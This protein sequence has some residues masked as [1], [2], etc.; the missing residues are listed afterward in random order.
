MQRTIFRLLQFITLVGLLFGVWLGSQRVARSLAAPGGHA[1]VGTTTLTINPATNNAGAV[2]ELIGAIS[3]ANADSAA[4]T[5]NLFPNGVYTFSAAQN[6][7]FGP[8]ALPQISSDITI[9]GNG[10]TLL[11]A[12]N[13]PKFRFF[14]VSGG[15]SF[16]AATG[17][18]LR[19]GSLTLKDLTMQDGLARGGTSGQGGG[20]AGLGGAIFNQ[21]TLALERV[22]MT[23]NT[24]QGGATNNTVFNAGGGIGTD[25]SE[26]IG[27]GPVGGGFGTP[28]AG[29][30]GAGGTAQNDASGAGGGGFRP[31][32]N[33]ASVVANS[34]IGGAG[35]GQGKLGGRGENASNGAGGNNGDGG[36]GGGGNAFFPSSGGSYGNAGTFGGGGGV[37]GGGG[38]GFIGRAA[39]G[40][41]FGGGGGQSDGAGGQGGFGGG[42]G[43][44]SVGG[45]GGFGGGAG[46]LNTA[47]FGG[48]GGAGGGM[49]GALFNLAGTVTLTNCTLSGNTAQGGDS[50]TVTVLQNSSSGNGGSGFGGALFNLNGALTLNNCTVASNN[51]IAGLGGASGSNGQAQGGA[52]YNL[53]FGNRITDG[54][55]TTASAIARNSIFALSNVSSDVVCERRNGSQTNMATVNLSDRNLVMSLPP[56]IGGG[57]ITGTPVSSNNPG[58][59][60]LALNRPGLT[61]TQMIGN[62]SPAFNQGNAATCAAT[63][64]RG[65][66]R[67]REG[68]C[69]LGAVE[70]V[71]CQTLTITPA[72]LPDAVLQTPYT[73][74]LSSTPG[75]GQP[76]FGLTSGSLPPGLSL[77]SNGAFSGV[78]T[79]PGQFSF[80]VTVSDIFNCVSSRQY[81]LNVTANCA[82]SLTVNDLGDTSDALAGDGVCADAAGHCTL[83]AAIEEAGALAPC[84]EIAINLNVAGVINLGTALPPL[85][86]DLRLVGP[87]A[88]LLTIQRQAAALFRILEIA[89]GRTLNLSGV[90]VRNGSVSGLLVEGGGILTNGYSTLTDCVIAD[91]T[92]NGGDGGGLAVS[93][94]GSASLVRTIV[95]NNQAQGGQGFGGGI[96]GIGALSLTNCTVTGN[97]A[98]AGGGGIYAGGIFLLEN[99]SVSGNVAPAGGG[100]EVAS[101]S[102]KI[103]NSTI[104]GNTVT[105]PTNGGGLVLVSF[106]GFGP[107]AWELTL[108][109]TTLA[110]NGDNIALLNFNCNGSMM[111][112]MANTLVVG[113]LTPNFRK[114]G[115]T[116]QSLGHNLD[117]DG[118][119]GLVNGTLNDL[120]G[121]QAMPLDARLA[122][123]S[124]YG[125]LTQTHALLC[126]S[127]A[128][129]AGDNTAATNQG[130]TTDQ[131]GVSR[132]INGAVDIGAFE[133][134]L[135]INGALPN[136][137]AN[138]PYNQT[139]TATGGTGNKTFALIGGALPNG[140]ALNANGVLTGIPTQIGTFN[141]TMLATDAAGMAGVCQITL[142]ITCPVITVRVR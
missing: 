12:A 89:G 5:I 130:L 65:V 44:G 23:G 25:A 139:L 35:G 107:G 96:S 47:I 48:V 115:A 85:T 82:A 122:P 74:T 111:L 140:L 134:H 97:Q 2:A 98:E 92:S 3:A 108:V 81:T 142:T 94:A 41:G 52:L 73:Q 72:T 58:L 104:S 53:A 42:G 117:S 133:N 14:Y 129:D 63:D 26:V 114:F 9:L 70:F 71:S 13:A 62:T 33:G 32:D 66:T 4:D 20:G 10:A 83:R 51:V 109:N 57:T 24:A 1:V 121:T 91:S 124:N 54:G 45:S 36:G 112:K 22:T 15:L 103:V 90:T 105:T 28:F 118:S 30:G 120:I 21:G 88:A 78:P 119:S 113:G 132:Q 110:N 125:G 7:E 8:N 100:V 11:R 123:L 77:N 50:T 137:S 68:G 29:V 79:Q 19:A 106:C 75:N 127:P 59:S 55:A 101:Q 67:P 87:G 64:Q 86:H 17:Q 27:F 84:G 60:V 49:G 102:S 37:G 16:N 56:A 6:A 138:A 76:L 80:T 116:I 136:A 39:G 93:G 61:P 43:G 126:G 128:L 34:L 40:G 38:P 69:D 18:G 135:S 141:F 31:G 95:R 99:S 131:R 46:G